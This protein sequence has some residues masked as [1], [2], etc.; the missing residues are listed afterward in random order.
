MFETLS[1]LKNKKLKVNNIL[2]QK[3]KDMFLN[4][5]FEQDYYSRTATGIYKI[6]HDSIRQTNWLAYYRR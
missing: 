3:H 6:G 4:P 5:H 1:T 2:I